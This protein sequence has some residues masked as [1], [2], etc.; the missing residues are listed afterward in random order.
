M[1][2]IRQSEQIPDN[3][4]AVSTENVTVGLG[5]VVVLAL[6]QF[7]ELK[8]VKGDEVKLTVH[9]ITT[10]TYLRKRFRFPYKNEVKRGLKVL[11]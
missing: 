2:H 11:K 6:G 10:T 8:G 7:V 5:K 3:G 4:I 1:R 9:D